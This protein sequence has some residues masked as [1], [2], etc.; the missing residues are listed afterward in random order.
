MNR[1]TDYRG[2][3]RQFQYLR[4]MFM[5]P[6]VPVSMSWWAYVRYGEA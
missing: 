2:K 4:N 1:V 6:P 5:L 3:E